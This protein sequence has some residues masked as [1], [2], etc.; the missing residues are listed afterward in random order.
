MAGTET[1]GD[2]ANVLEKKAKASE[3]LFNLEPTEE[4]RKAWKQAQ[5]AAQGTKQHHMSEKKRIA[6]ENAEYNAQESLALE[7]ERVG[8][9]KVGQQLLANVPNSP[10]K[11][12]ETIKYDNI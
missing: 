5:G 2:Y 1:Y 12:G 4:N 7:Q 10:R 6:K 3:H 11:K 8:K 9:S